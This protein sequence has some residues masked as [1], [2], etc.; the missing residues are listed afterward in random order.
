[1]KSYAG[2]K[3][4]F[5]LSLFIVFLLLL[6]CAG[7]GPVDV[8]AEAPAA[9]QPAA[10]T[11]AADDEAPVPESVVDASPDRLVLAARY[12]QEDVVRYLL[13]GG[14]D[15]NVTDAYGNTP[16]I[17]AA[18]NGQHSMVRLLLARNAD[19]NAVNEEENSALMAAA[20][21]GDYRLSHA[22][23][24]AGAGVDRRNNQ[25]ETALFFAVRYG[26]LVTARVLLN[27]GAAPNIRNTV[28]VNL[29]NSGYTPLIYAADHGV[30]DE[31]V[32]WSAIA[33]LLLDNGAD[34]NLANTHGEPPMAF[35]Q[36]RNDQDL[37][38]VLVAGGAKD[39]QVYTT[40]NSDEALL[41]AA[42]VND[43]FQVRRVLRD[44]A[45][46]NFVDPNGI[47]P[48]LAAALEGNRD[49]VRILVEA[50][51]EINY[52]PSG[53]RQFAMSRSHAPLSE[54]ALMQA[55]SRGDTPLVAAGRAGHRD[56]V[57]YLLE[58]GADVDLAN[59][60]GQTVLFL[61]VTRGDAPLTGILLSNGA[62]PNTLE[63][64]NRANRVTAARAGL[65][66]DSLLI[67][68]V[69]NGHEEITRLLLEAAAR[70]D[71]RGYMGKTALYW[72]VEKERTVIARMLTGQGVD[73]DISTF[74]GM[75]PLMEAARLGNVQLARLL[76]D[77]GANVNVIQQPE[78]GYDSSSYDAGGMTAL[79]FAARGGHAE[80][81]NVL[82][83]A[84]AEVNIHNGR[85]MSAIQEAAANGHMEVVE[86]LRAAGSRDQVGL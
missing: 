56:T 27:A 35:A 59:R 57:A 52:V 45:N 41:K 30:I 13:D 25:G 44:G 34:P 77:S 84:H 39:V 18:G 6:G 74:A 67:K 32:D 3:C 37:M 43:V 17:A 50:G 60:Q 21:M 61:A 4:L 51:A 26:H 46:V 54:R 1:M 71:Y 8:R 9:A 82:L 15:V 76:L 66:R 69:Q 55:A 36:K 2:L 11:A 10:L 70:A 23:L 79:I 29:P 31:A 64:D 68:A 83:A 75:T 65:G 85:E 20:A 42:R 22:L 24:A 73:P 7:K 49:I 53:L 47:T 38:E 5:Q 80:M 72:A 33:K 19:V 81:V 58:Q 62:D 16:L 86:L 78:L 28:R 48:L 12:G 14:M 63:Q 40:L